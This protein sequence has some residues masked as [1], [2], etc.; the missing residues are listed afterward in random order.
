MIKNIFKSKLGIT[1]FKYLIKS[2]I[3]SIIC[4]LVMYGA[5]LVICHNENERYKAEVNTI[6]K[7][8]MKDIIDFVED[9]DISSSQINEI[10]RFSGIYSKVDLAIIKDNKVIYN[11]DNIDLE[12]IILSD[13]ED[14][15]SIN[16]DDGNV[17]GIF[18]IKFK[19]GDAIAIVKERYDEVLFTTLIIISSVVSIITFIVVFIMQLNKK[20]G[21]IN[22]IKEYIH[23]LEG[24]DLDHLIPI[25][26]NDELS[27]L[28]ISINNMS[29]SMKDRIQGEL[30]AQNA[31]K[32]LITNI[33]HD[34][35]TPLTP[36]IG[37]L[38]LIKEGKYSDDIQRD[39]FIDI[40]LDKATQLKT[41]ANLLFEYS[42]LYSNQ[43]QLDIENVEVN[44][45]IEQ[46]TFENE[47]LLKKHGFDVEV[48][49]K[50]DGKFKLDIDINQLNRVFDNIISNI[51]KYGDSSFKVKFDFFIN[52]SNFNM[53][54]INNIDENNDHAESTGL[55]INI[56]KSIM[57]LHG[58]DFK[59][60][61][62][63]DIFKSIV[64]LPIKN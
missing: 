27:D 64:I 32:E 30:D 5:S 29:S 46:F 18:N 36:I 54:I 23:V 40:V 28:A 14:H 9:N 45:L 58:G 37:Y 24:G 2:L 35:R 59:D 52:K 39:K 63:S 25:K 51:I 20:I 10:A 11:S 42:M 6:T 62:E 33:S 26:D 21:Y 48:N 41:R 50:V 1:I 44:A 3:V 17:E 56:C 34:I 60:I 22:E 31:N 15:S 47:L 8:L 49:N 13:D 57:R 12:N 38:T 7:D 53:Y 16:L 4:F 61:N 19:D 55:G 43:K